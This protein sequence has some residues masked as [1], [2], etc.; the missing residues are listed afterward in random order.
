VQCVESLRVQAYFDGELD[1]LDALEIERHIA[2]CAECRALLA[3]L[4]EVRAALRAELP[5]ERAPQAL[6]ARIGQA[7][8]TEADRA[9][10]ALPP[11]RPPAAWRTRAFWL[12]A[13][14]GLGAA[15]LAGVA[16]LVLTPLLRAPEQALLTQLV[17]AHVHSLLP[18]QLTAVI[19]TDRHTVRPWFAGHADVSPV[20]AD[21]AAQGYP[22]IGGRADALAGQRAAVVVYRHGAHLINVFSWVAPEQALP[23]SATRN[24]Y[25]ALCWRA[26]NLQYCAVSDTGWD[27]LQALAQLLQELAAQDAA[28]KRPLRE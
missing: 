26:G 21:F 6:R 19:S 9:A 17:A 7:L 23:A 2:H 27:E 15:L 18:G 4:R 8:A 10:A 12:G 3:E 22:L 13:G 28:P 11:L 1:A 16:L 20:V 5:Y 14:G 25:H 24:G